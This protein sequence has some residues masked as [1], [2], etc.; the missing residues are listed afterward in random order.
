MFFFGL[1]IRMRGKSQIDAFW[2]LASAG[3]LALMRALPEPVN[4]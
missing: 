3:S 1:M 2:V 4:L